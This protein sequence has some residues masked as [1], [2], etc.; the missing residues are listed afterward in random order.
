MVGQAIRYLLTGSK[1]HG[2]NPQYEVYS[3]VGDNVFPNVIPQN[4]GLPALVYTIRDSTPANIKYHRPIAITIDVE[5]DVIADNYAELSQ[6]S[7]LIKNN[8]HRYKNTY[9]SNDSDG[10]GYGSNSEYSGFLD[11]FGMF[12]PASNDSIQ[13]VG[14]LQIIDLSFTDSTE[15]FDDVLENYRNTL[16]FKLTYLNDATIW[17]ADFYLKI[18]QLNLMYKT[19]TDPKY[20]NVDINDG[21]NYLFSPSTF[22]TILSKSY[23][24]IY[25]QFYESD[26]NRPTIKK[27]ESN[28][29]KLN[30][31]NY[32]EFGED[33]YLSNY[34]DMT[35]A[36]K[37]DEVTIFCVFSFPDSYFTASPVGGA[38]LLQDTGSGAENGGFGVYSFS[39]GITNHWRFYAT[40][41][42][43]NGSGGT[44]WRFFNIM[45]FN[46]ITPIIN[47][48]TRFSDPVFF[49][50]SLSKKD[51]TTLSGQY[52]FITS[53]DFTE[54]G[55]DNIYENFEGTSTSTWKDNFFNYK[56]IHSDMS[57][58]DTGNTSIGIGGI[59]PVNN[60]IN[61]F[62]LIVYPKKLVFG[63]PEYMEI[64]KQ[65][66]EKHNMLNRTTN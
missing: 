35:I 15:S 50:F 10:I 38:I 46:T 49:A 26:A 59:L 44:Q 32:L 51:S 1:S 27:S 13:Y 52:D 25:T 66:I 42:E 24:G 2:N 64:K 19:G 6:I 54:F 22:S 3:Y 48:N 8:L 34:L 7:L 47:P 36:R 31:L 43:D 41:L 55:D 20:I 56:T 58:I 30:Q 37:L 9:N 40:A 33:K 65:V 39:S 21:V 16:S 14:G 17:G 4:Y 61:L 60:A 12:A 28:P 53:S 29:P 45:G 63:S 57:S 62:D 18:Q 23:D 5:I 11:E